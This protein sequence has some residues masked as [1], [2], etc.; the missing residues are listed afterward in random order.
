M[1]KVRRKTGSQNHEA[2]I[3][4]LLNLPIVGD[5]PEVSGSA[6]RATG[7]AKTCQSSE[8][9]GLILLVSKS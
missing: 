4:L 9:L 1:K 2:W 8:F 6:G 7:A 3:F 5:A